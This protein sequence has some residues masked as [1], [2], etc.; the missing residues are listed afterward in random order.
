MAKRLPLAE[1]V[2]DQELDETHY[3]GIPASG[4]STLCG[5]AEGRGLKDQGMPTDAPV[6][7]RGCIAAVRYFQSHQFD[8]LPEA[9]HGKG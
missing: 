1:K 8:P 7:C 6:D 3:V 4:K 9:G 2:Y 5:L